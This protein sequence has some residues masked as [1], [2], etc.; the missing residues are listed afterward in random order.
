MQLPPASVLDELQLDQL[1]A[2]SCHSE[3]IIDCECLKQR[4]ARRVGTR[5]RGRLLG[6]LDDISG[7]TGGVWRSLATTSRL[8]RVMKGLRGHVREVAERRK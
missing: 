5:T 2:A 7:E 8:A 1:W 4:E 6:K 3:S